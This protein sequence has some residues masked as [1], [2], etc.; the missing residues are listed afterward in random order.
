[1]MPVNINKRSRPTSDNLCSR[2]VNDLRE[3]IVRGD[4]K[5][6]FAIREASLS[7]TLNISRTPVREALKILETEGLVSIRKNQGARVSAVNLAEAYELFEAA[8]GIERY[9]AELATVR[10]STADY[11]KLETLQTTLERAFLAGDLKK[12]FEV[13]QN[14]HLSIVKMAYNAALQSLHDGVFAHIRR[15]RYFALN[16][17]RR[18]HDSVD[19]HRAILNALRRGDPRETGSLLESHVLATGRAI[20]QVSA[21]KKPRNVSG[22]PHGRS[23]SARNRKSSPQGIE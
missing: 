20:A 9:A 3:M 13:N 12:Y 21:Q 2:T 5:P 4:I 23:A 16:A 8:A 17:D 11:K 22:L 1:M 14:I 18:W 10:H 15:L 19:E 7:Q 6:G